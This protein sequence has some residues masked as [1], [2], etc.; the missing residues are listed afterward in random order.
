[1]FFIRTGRSLVN[2]MVLALLPIRTAQLTNLAHQLPARA[3]HLESF[4]KCSLGFFMVLLLLW[5]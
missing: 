4:A 2:L 5:D 3:Q 1:M